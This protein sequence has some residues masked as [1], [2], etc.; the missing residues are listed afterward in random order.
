MTGLTLAALAAVAVGAWAVTQDDDDDIA[1]RRIFRLENRHRYFIAWR[2]P[3]PTAVYDLAQVQAM[4]SSLGFCDF[5]DPTLI[6]PE[7]QFSAD[8]CLPDRDWVVPAPVAIV[9]V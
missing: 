5:S 1:A 9:E 7:I 2:L 8:W 6:G 4:F 3:D